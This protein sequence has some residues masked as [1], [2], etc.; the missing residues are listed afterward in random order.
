MARNSRS[1]ISITD[2]Y[3][4]YSQLEA[5]ARGK[6]PA[7]IQQLDTTRF[8]TFAFTLGDSLQNVIWVVFSADIGIKGHYTNLVVSVLG[9]NSR[10]YTY[11]S[12]NTVT[13]AK[14]R[15]DFPVFT[16][17]LS[18]NE[19]RH[20][21]VL[22]KDSLYFLAVKRKTFRSVGLDMTTTTREILPIRSG[23]VHKGLRGISGVWERRWSWRKQFIEFAPQILDDLGIRFDDWLYKTA[24]STTKRS[25]TKG[26]ANKK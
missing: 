20:F 1:E 8:A 12:W 25:D 23:L 3:A 13:V 19:Q 9:Y 21:A 2:V 6:L 11:Q 16:K 10:A 24:T 15:D 5:M 26:E 14:L 7:V 4:K 17:L 18:V 22:I